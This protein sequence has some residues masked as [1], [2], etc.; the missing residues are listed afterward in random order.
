[1]PSKAACSK[2][3]DPAKGTHFI[4]YFKAKDLDE[5]LGHV[6]KGKPALTDLQIKR[7]RMLKITPDQ[8]KALVAWAYDNNLDT[9]TN[10]HGFLNQ[11]VYENNPSLHQLLG[12]MAYRHGGSFMTSSTAGYIGLADAIKYALNPTAEVSSKKATAT[13]ER[14]LFKQGTYAKDKEKDNARYA[15][16]Q[17]RFK[18]FK[19]NVTG[20]SVAVKPAYVGGTGSSNITLYK[21]TPIN[22]KKI[23]ILNPDYVN[24][25]SLKL[26]AYNLTRQ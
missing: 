25:D 13:M 24:V 5:Y 18:R 10:S 14:L 2:I 23:K 7:R 21:Q 11:D 26:P 16:L 6:K 12:D 8:T 3:K 19:D 15:F 4:N 22:K 20:D 9:L 17:D 1:M